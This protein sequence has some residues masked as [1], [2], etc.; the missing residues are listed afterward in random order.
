MSWTKK[1]LI[2]Q[3]F[4]EIGL[5]DYIYD[6]TPEQL[7]SAVNK[8]DSIV[9]NWET[10]GVRISY[11]MS[12]NPSS[13]NINALSNI[14]SFANEAIYLNLALRLAPSFGKTVSQETKLAAFNAYSNL[15]SKLTTVA[16]RNLTTDLPLGQGNKPWRNGG[17]DYIFPP[18]DD[19]LVGGDG[20]LEL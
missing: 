4:E 14:P 10:Q 15:I 17:N 8:M 11:P 18:P 13:A 7:Q 12:D 1:Q 2:V 20:I 19:I 16:Q 9:A 3:A 5:A 6:L